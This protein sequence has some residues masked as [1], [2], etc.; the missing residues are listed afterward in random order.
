MK[1]SIMV[2]ALSVAFASVALAKPAFIKGAKCI[3]CHTEAMGKKTNVSA[4]S[5]EMVKKY[6]GQKCADCHAA[7]EDGKKLLCTDAKLCKKK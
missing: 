1:K 2:L 4:P 6:P 7:S 3:T 5:L